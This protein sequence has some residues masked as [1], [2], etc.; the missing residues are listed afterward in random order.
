M[1]NYTKE[2]KILAH[3]FADALN[4][5]KSIGMHLSYIRLYEEWSL[6][7][8]LKKVLDKP[9]NEIVTNRAAYYNYCVQANG[10]LKRSR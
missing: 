5:H 9:D 4:D 3:E 6:R 8:Q 1:S 10:V 7:E 2:E